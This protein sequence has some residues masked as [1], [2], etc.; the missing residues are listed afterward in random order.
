[1]RLGVWYVSERKMKRDMG[2]ESQSQSERQRLGEK[3]RVWYACLTG[4]LASWL[5]VHV[6]VCA[7]P[8]IVIVLRIVSHYKCNQYYS[9]YVCT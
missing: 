7:Y 5:A 4:W 9:S 3:R 6:C 8:G 1:M 2:T